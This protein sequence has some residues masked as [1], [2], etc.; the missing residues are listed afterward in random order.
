MASEQQTIL[1]RVNLLGGFALSF[2]GTPV[3]GLRA[4]RVQLL[5]SYLLLH[6][7]APQRRQHLAF[8]LWPDSSEA[9][10]HTNLRNLIHLLRRDLP[11]PDRFFYVDALTV[12]WLP[13]APALL[14]VAEFERAE[15]AGDDET[16]VSQCQGPLLPGFYDDW[17][18]VERERLDQIYVEA[19][20]RLVQRHRNAGNLHA[21]IRYAERL[22]Q[23]DPLRE[24]AVRDLMLLHASNGDRAAALRAYHACAAALQNSLG[25]DPSAPTQAAYR[26]VMALPAPAALPSSTLSAPILVGRADEWKRLCQE[27]QNAAAGG[28]QVTLVTGEAGIGKTRLVADLAAWVGRQGNR[29]ATAACYQAEGRLPFAP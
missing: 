12:Q 19:L 22:A 6:R 7:Q 20:G 25:V 16:A 28:P 13:D 5:L 2:N 14:D 23:H 24:A 26:Q 27:W 4:P 29:V 3:R 8:L 1:L 17:V 9:Q 10:A 21:A 15:A 18:I 11:E